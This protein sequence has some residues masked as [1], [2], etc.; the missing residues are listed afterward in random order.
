MIKGA[1]EPIEKET[2][3]QRSGF[4]EMLLDTLG[5]ILLGSMLV[6]KGA[7]ATSWRKRE[8]IRAGQDF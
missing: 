1:T 3:E 6:S 8:A 4:L 5:A 7:T 2:K